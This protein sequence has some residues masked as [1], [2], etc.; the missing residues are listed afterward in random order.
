VTDLREVGTQIRDAAGGLILA[1]HVLARIVAF[2]PGP[3]IFVDADLPAHLAADPGSVFI[4]SGSTVLLA[5]FQ[6]A[7]TVDPSVPHNRSSVE[8]ATWRRSD[9]RRISLEGGLE[10]RNSDFDWQ[11]AQGEAWPRGA[12]VTLSY[13]DHQTVRLPLAQYPSDLQ[14]AAARSITQELLADL[15]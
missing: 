15:A 11:S 7:V 10:G 4:I 5:T 1:D 3:T 2:L 13:K 6:N 12:V 8:V 14:V 9:L